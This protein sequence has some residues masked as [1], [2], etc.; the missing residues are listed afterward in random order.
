[1]ILRSTI[2]PRASITNMFYALLVIVLVLAV[3]YKYANNTFDYWKKR[4]VPFH[5]PVTFFG[6]LRDSITMK[7]SLGQIYTEIYNSYPNAPY[8]GFFK[9]RKPGLL[10]RDIEIIKNIFIKDFNSFQKNDFFVDENVDPIFSRNPFVQHGERWKT[11]RSQLSY[12]FTSGKMK[13]MFP[14]MH[15]I[16]QN[17]VKYIENEIKLGG[18]PFETKELAGKFTSDN[19]ATCAFGMDGKS[20]EDPNSEFRS[21]GRRILQPSIS[22]NI[23]MLLMTLFPACTKLLKIRFVPQDAADYFKNIIQTTLKYRKDN[24]IVRNDFLDVVTQMKFKS[25]DPPLDEDDITAHAISFFGDGFETSSIALSFTLYNLAANLDVQEKLRDE[26]H[27]TIESNDG[28]LTYESVQSMTYLDCVLSE[29]LRMHPPGVSLSKICT[30][31]YNLPP[32]DESGKEVEIEADTPIV[33]PVY[34]LHNDPKYFPNPEVFDPER[35]SDHSTIVKGSYLPFGEGARIC[36]GM[37]FAILQV[38]IAIIS[39]VQNFDIRVNKKT[40]QPLEIDPTHFL[41]L[42]KGGLWLD[43]H[44]LDK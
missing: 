34:G 28:E 12:C 5:P 41:L 1:W 2:W 35:F 36:V 29:S 40:K 24:K 25:D 7:R 42:A 27:K 4:N 15:A 16:S 23:K 33:I 17:M 26:I 39:I 38:K 13:H 44:K 6:N 31:T 11:S 20:F 32:C 3:L 8:V 22:L 37:K 18:N 43:Y 10:I 9:M 21:V 30:A 19:V 14:L